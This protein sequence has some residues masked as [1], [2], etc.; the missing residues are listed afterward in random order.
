MRP[1]YLGEVTQLHSDVNQLV[2]WGVVTGTAKADIA[3]GR[4]PTRATIRRRPVRRSGVHSRAAHEI[5][6]AAHRILSTKHVRAQQQVPREH[7]VLVGRG[8]AMGGAWVHPR[9]RG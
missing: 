4:H 3:V 6:V 8:L 7:C 9:G 2:R 5:G 1:I